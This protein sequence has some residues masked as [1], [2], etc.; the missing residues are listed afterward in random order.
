[1]ENERGLGAKLTRMEKAHPLAFKSG[2]PAFVTEFSFLVV[3]LVLWGMQAAF[4]SFDALQRAIGWLPI[5]EA[6]IGILILPLSVGILQYKDCKRQRKY[7]FFRN[8]G[9]LL[10]PTLG[11]SLLCAT[12]N[13]LLMKV[14]FGGGQS[15]NPK[16]LVLV[17]ITA[18][19]DFVVAAVCQA[20]LIIFRA[21]NE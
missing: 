9:F 21:R 7:V 11:F 16:V 14:A 4:G 12:V 17:A 18:L 13:E 5:F 3:I 8:I 20:I 6:V 2:Y 1:M 15:Y 10:V 19:A